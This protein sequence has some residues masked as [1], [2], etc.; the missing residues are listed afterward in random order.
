MHHV[1][2]RWDVALEKGASF[3]TIHWDKGWKDFHEVPGL[4]LW[5]MVHPPDHRRSGGSMAHGA[6]GSMFVVESDLLRADDGPQVY[7]SP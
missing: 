2:R 1:R 4:Q 6:H 5:L 3:H 7:R